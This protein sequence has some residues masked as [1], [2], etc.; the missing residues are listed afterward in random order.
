MGRGVLIRNMLT[1][2]YPNLRRLEMRARLQHLVAVCVPYKPAEG[3]SDVEASI[4]CFFLLHSSAL[5][6][7]TEQVHH[8]TSLESF[9]CTCWH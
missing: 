1:V 3:V 2:T 8:A 6:P 7:T 5:V 4:A 9:C